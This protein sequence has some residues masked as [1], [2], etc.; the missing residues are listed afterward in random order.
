MLRSEELISFGGVNMQRAVAE[1]AG[2]AP[3]SILRCPR[4]FCLD[5]S[6]G[7]LPRANWLT[8]DVGDFKELFLRANYLRPLQA[9]YPGFA[10]LVDEDG[11]GC[12]AFWPQLIKIEKDNDGII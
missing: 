7:W 8:F 9:L 5:W 12:A 4:S 11:M 2:L 3:V 10:G 6:G 1:K